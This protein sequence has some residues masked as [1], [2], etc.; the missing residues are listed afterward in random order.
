MDNMKTL[1]VPMA[2]T[3]LLLMA[4][5][6]L[7]APPQDAGMPFVS[8]KDDQNPCR[9]LV[10][11]GGGR[12]LNMLCFGARGSLPIVIFLQGL[13]NEDITDW[14]FVQSPIAR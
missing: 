13:G 10:D 12:R 1:M 6:A 14:R 2:L 7:A 4:S 11:I 8:M 9:H 5:G 3:G